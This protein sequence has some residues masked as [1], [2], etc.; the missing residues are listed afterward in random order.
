[1]KKYFIFTML[2]L[3]MSTVLLAQRPAT[4]QT[5][6]EDSS[7]PPPPPPKPAEITPPVREIEVYTPPTP[8]RDFVSP[9]VKEI[10]VYAPPTETT[11]PT[12]CPPMPTST[13]RNNSTETVI[14]EPQF[15]VENNSSSSV[16]VSNSTSVQTQQETNLQPYYLQKPTA[17][18]ALHKLIVMSDVAKSYILGFQ[19][20]RKSSWRDN[21]AVA[22]RHI[23]EML[24]LAVFLP[25]K[26]FAKVQPLMR[27]IYISLDGIVEN[28][29]I[30][31]SIPIIY[32]RLQRCNTYYE[33]LGNQLN[34]ILIKID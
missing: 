25:T 30:G 20:Q 18:E 1:M 29:T 7:P 3:S 4:A 12:M 13:P 11:S 2:C 9:P 14:V 23:Y 6:E 22:R 24:N 8:P 27:D 17:E 21:S 5:F 28:R 33:Q 16:F 32:E 10:E 15:F 19:T 31:E 26:N 34:E